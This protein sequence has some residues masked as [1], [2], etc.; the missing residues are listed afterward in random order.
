MSFSRF[1]SCLVIALYAGAAGAFSFEDVAERA[2]L[3]ARQPYRDTSRKAP[4]QLTA[5]SY[6]Q[7]RDIRFRPD[8]ALWRTEELPFE[9]MFF[10][11]GKFQKQ[12]VRIE[13][14]TPQGTRHIPYRAADFDFGKNK[15]SP[16]SWGDLGF[17][18]FRAH[19]P[20]NSTAYKD[21]VVVFLGASYFRALGAGERYGLSAR[22]LAIDTVGGQG[23][24]FP[25]FIRFWA[26]KPSA[27][28]NVL[29]VYALLDSQR[30]TGA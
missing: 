29:T 10:H 9:L 24:E 26:V 13:E 2:Q 15:I 6:D 18:G 4:A 16:Q 5:L 21:E 3:Q 27:D 22:G 23:E 30:A 17:A 7:Y 14:V 28:A 8:R 19:Y 12:A 1:A 25:A 11:L 20:L